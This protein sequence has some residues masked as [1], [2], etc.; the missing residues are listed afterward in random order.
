MV[1]DPCAN[2]LL[3]HLPAR[4]PDYSIKSIPR[5]KLKAKIFNAN[6]SFEDLGILSMETQKIFGISQKGVNS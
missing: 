4:T 6:K 5:Y 1:E 3:P 2:L